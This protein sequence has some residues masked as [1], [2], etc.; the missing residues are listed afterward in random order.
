MKPRVK[1][2]E[3]GFVTVDAGLISLGDPCYMSDGGN[4]F[5]DWSAFCDKHQRNERDGVHQ[6]DN[7]KAVIV[8]SG[9]GDGIYPVEVKREDG[10]IKEVR[11]KFF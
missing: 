9:M 11:I 3:I 8:S 4:D 2:E 1:W 6:L 10:M 7:G 5:E